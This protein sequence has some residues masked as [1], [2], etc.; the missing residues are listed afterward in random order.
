[1]SLGTEVGL[2]QADIV[3]DGDSAPQ[4]G[5]QSPI[6]GGQTAGCIS[7]PLG[8]EVDLGPGVLTDFYQIWRGDAVRPS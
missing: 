8:T 2:G 5:A 1:M 4:K 3:L 6:F 7:I